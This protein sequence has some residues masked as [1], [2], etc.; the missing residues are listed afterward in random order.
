MSGAARSLGVL[1]AAS[2]LLFPG[3]AEDG[4]DDDTVQ[5]L[6]ECG[7][8]A[9]SPGA[10][11]SLIPEPFMLD[12]DAEI[13]QVEIIDKRVVGGLGLRQTVDQAFERYKAAIPEASFELLQEDNEHFEAELYIKKGKELGSLQI[14]SS[15]CPQAVI[16][17]LNLPP[18][19]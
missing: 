8:P 2:M 4:S 12:G 9:P 11:V 13:V 5:D 18:E 14:R 7:L 3:C 10:D 17:Y 16:V 15:T 6:T 19:S 1:V